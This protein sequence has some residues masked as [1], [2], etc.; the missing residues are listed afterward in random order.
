MKHILHLIAL[1]LVLATLPVASRAQGDDAGVQSKIGS[2]DCMAWSPK[3]DRRFTGWTGGCSGGLAQGAGV[4]TG[5]WRDDKGAWRPFRYGGKLVA[6]KRSGFGRARFEGSGEFAGQYRDD[7]LDGW[8]LMRLEDGSTYEGQW[9][10]AKRHGLGTFTTRSGYV[11]RGRWTDDVLGAYQQDASDGRSW[12]VLD[13]RPD[14]TAGGV[15]DASGEVEAGTYRRQDGNWLREG[16]GVFHFEKQGSVYLGEFAA[17]LPDGAGVFVLPDKGNPADASVYGGQF[18]N[19]CLWRG[20]YYTN[21]IVAA[22]SC[23]RR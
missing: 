11:I 23:R 4:L 17:D 19:G 14:G 16:H 5:E 20:N 3:P 13:V 8:A 18:R 22:D 7:N 1:L 9:L 21:V 6:G 2:T 15:F 10:Q 12:E